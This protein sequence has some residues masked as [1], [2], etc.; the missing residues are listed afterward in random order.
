MRT[1]AE[2][3]WEK[4]DR[5]GPSDCW[6]WTAST[7]TGGYGII[8]RKGVK[9]MALA[10]RIAWEFAYGAAGEGM[11]VLHHCDNPKCCNP[12]H[13][14]L[15]SRADNNRDKVQ[16]GRQVKGRTNGRTKLTEE[17]V[18]SIREDPRSERELGRIYGVQHTAIGMIRRG[19]SWAWLRSRGE[20]V[21]T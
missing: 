7:D 2:R 16:K 6:N 18:I 19:E 21:G 20:A 8:G 9:G 14:W 10:H 5:R 4:V 17:Q 3:F 15:G 12:Y 11:C 13:L 1:L